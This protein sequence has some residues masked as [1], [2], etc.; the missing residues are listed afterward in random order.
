MSLPP[1]RITTSAACRWSGTAPYLEISTTTLRRADAVRRP[2]RPAL[3]RRARRCPRRGQ[4]GVDGAVPPPALSRSAARSRDPAQSMFSITC[5][6]SASPDA[7][8]REGQDARVR[9]DPAGRVELR[10]RARSMSGR[11]RAFSVAGE[12]RARGA[13]S[14]GACGR[15]SSPEEAAAG[16]RCS[17]RARPVEPADLVVLAVGV[18]VAVLRAADLVAGERASA[19]PATA[20]GWRRS[21]CIC[22]V[23][24]RLDRPA[25]SVGPSTPQFQLRLSSMPSRLPSPLASLC[26]SL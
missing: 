4:R 2:V 10:S 6:S 15:R 19:R 8:H 25:S 5:R 9:V 26:F 24:Q 13:R 20:S 12:E 18:V 11:P 17:S 1:R 7:A 23:A 21:S 22:R 14:G 3:L 16:R